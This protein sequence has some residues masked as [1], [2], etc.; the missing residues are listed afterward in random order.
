LGTGIGVCPADCCVPE[1]A[2]SGERRA[3]VAKDIT[4]QH[5]MILAFLFFMDVVVLG[6]LFLIAMNKIYL[7]P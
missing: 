2:Q 6:C 7:L 1:G 5:W 3:S 4:I